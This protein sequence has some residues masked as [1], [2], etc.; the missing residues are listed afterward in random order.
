M[1]ASSQ[2]TKNIDICCCSHDHTDDCRWHKYFL[3]YP[4]KAH[5]L[6]SGKCK[7]EFA[8]NEHKPDCLLLIEYMKFFREE[9]DLE[10]T[11]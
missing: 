9:L 10:Q 11:K 2:C 6:H 8:N 7:C 5:K 4:I 3:K 1:V